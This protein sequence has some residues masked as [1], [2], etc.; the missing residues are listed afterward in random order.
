MTSMAAPYSLNL[1]QPIDRTAPSAPE[2]VFSVKEMLRKL[3][4]YHPSKFEITGITDEQ[5]FDGIKGFQRDEGLAEDGIMKPDGPTVRLLNAAS[6]EKRPGA[7]KGGRPGKT[8]RAPDGGIA[9][10]AFSLTDAVGQGGANNPRDVLGA[11]RALAWGGY[12]PREKAQSPPADVDPDFEFAIA[13]LQ[14]DFNLKRDQRMDPNGPSATLLARLIDEPITRHRE[15]EKARASKIVPNADQKSGDKR[16]DRDKPIA[17]G[18]GD[19][20]MGGSGD[21]ALRKETGAPSDGTEETNPPG[22]P[23][24]STDEEVS[25]DEM[26]AALEFDPEGESEWWL[27]LSY[28]WHAIAIRDLADGAIKNTKMNVESGKLPH[29]TPHNN[30]ADAYRHAYWLYSIAIEYG[31]ETAKR[32][33]DAHEVAK[34][35]DDGE[36]TMDLYNN[37]QAILAASNPDNSDRSAEEVAMELLNSGKL[38]TRPFPV[39]QEIRK[40]V[41]TKRSTRNSALIIPKI[42]PNTFDEC[43]ADRPF[44]GA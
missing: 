41:H 11:K 19:T 34:P 44:N 37:R 35:N 29:G 4:Y 24:P 33:G 6:W 18:N 17:A 42:T 38:R 22:L 3:G 20:L 25:V 31:P 10:P 40:R 5:M 2:D 30:A 15:Q 28:P 36:R 39:P 23:D 9:W 12:Y 13:G 26:Y 21:D 16:Q 27:M 32:V 8:S 43:E 7:P 14:R 1:Q